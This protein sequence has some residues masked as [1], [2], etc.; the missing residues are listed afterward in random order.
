MDMEYIIVDNKKYKITEIE[1]DEIYYRDEYGI[2]HA[3]PITQLVWSNF[4]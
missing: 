4:I 2:E 3:V 1:G